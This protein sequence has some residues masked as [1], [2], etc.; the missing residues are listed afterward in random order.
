[1]TGAADM[2][3]APSGKG[4]RRWGEMRRSRTGGRA[5]K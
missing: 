3:K 4:N 2:V 5:G 1:M